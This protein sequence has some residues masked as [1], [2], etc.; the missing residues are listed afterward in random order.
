M[1]HRQQDE[2]Y[3]D[4]LKIIQRKPNIFKTH[5]LYKANLSNQTLNDK[6][7]YMLKKQYIT[8][9]GTY[10]ITS[11]GIMFIN[12][13]EAFVEAVRKIDEVAL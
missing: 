2:I 4:M 9:G 13:Y 5:L 1:N 3:Y 10:V 12:A 7:K 8:N 6:I 11:R